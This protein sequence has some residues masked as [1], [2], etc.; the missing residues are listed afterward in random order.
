MKSKMAPKSNENTTLQTKPVSNNQD[1]SSSSSSSSSSD[2]EGESMS[3]ADIA[4]QRGL[5]FSRSTKRRKTSVSS[6]SATK[7]SKSHGSSLDEND[8]KDSSLY[9]MLLEAKARCDRYYHHKSKIFEF[10]L[11]HIKT[12]CCIRVLGT[13]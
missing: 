11:F 9:A 3:L 1:M 5:Q 13:K 12:C 10:V 8:P 2:E 6:K 7:K 4:R